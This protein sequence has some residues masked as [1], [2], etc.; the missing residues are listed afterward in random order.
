M[1]T[2]VKFTF[3]ITVIAKKILLNNYKIGRFSANF[4][5]FL[6]SIRLT[7][8]IT[9]KVVINEKILMFYTLK[10]MKLFNPT[11]PGHRPIHGVYHSL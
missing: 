4:C 10:I 11:V 3:L 1:A 5:Y 7:K 8:V 6:N 9:F 2:N